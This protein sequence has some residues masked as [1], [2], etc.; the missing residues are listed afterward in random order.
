[1]I[2][3]QLTLVVT[4]PIIIKKKKKKIEIAYPIKKW[5]ERWKWNNQCFISWRKTESKNHDNVESK[6]TKQKNQTGIQF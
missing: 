2:K 5:C 1:M 3:N 4:D 6:L